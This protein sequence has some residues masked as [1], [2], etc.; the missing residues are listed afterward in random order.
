MHT[1]SA[2]SLEKAGVDL[3][4]RFPR[5]PT[6]RRNQSIPLEIRGTDL[7]VKLCFDGTK[8]RLHESMKACPDAV[9]R[10]RIRATEDENNHP[11]PRQERSGTD[12]V[13][14]VSQLAIKTPSIVEIVTVDAS[15]KETR[16]YGCKVIPSHSPS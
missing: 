4:Q 12:M 7:E 2:V 14:W 16:A 8:V 10:Y 15:G 3:H 11:V 6:L 1:R 9:A 5:L 13:S